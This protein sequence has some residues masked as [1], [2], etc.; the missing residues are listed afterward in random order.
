MVPFPKCYGPPL[1][2]T[3]LTLSEPAKNRKTHLEEFFFTFYC[4][5]TQW[6]TIFIYYDFPKYHC[7]QRRFNFTHVSVAK[8]CSFRVSMFWWWEMLNCGITYK[9]LGET[10]G[11]STPILN[12]INNW[13]EH[14]FFVA[15]EM[16]KILNPGYTYRL[17]GCL[18]GCGPLT[19][20]WKPLLSQLS[21]A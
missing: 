16:R 9:P 21:Q 14:D 10:I 4:C 1:S 2:I 11:N 20:R 17:G 15:L 19:D 6:I 3:K 7:I 5:F 8:C 12:Q 18:W 13:L